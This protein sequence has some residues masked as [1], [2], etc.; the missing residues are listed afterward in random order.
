MA[1]MSDYLENTLIDHLFRNTQMATPG[2]VYVALYTD[3][4]T[5]ADTG[6]ELTAGGYARK[7]FTLAAPSG[8]T[9]SNDADIM[10]DAATEDWPTVTHI[11]IRDADTGGN[12][13]MHQALATPV[14][15]LDGNNFR[16]PAGEL[17]IAFD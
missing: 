14:N 5:D 2:T 8:G 9:A 6:T 15:I 10:F 12:L 3:D 13:L 16:I 4:P 17:T 11:G 7:S 1:Q